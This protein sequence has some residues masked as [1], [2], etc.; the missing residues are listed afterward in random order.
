M[1]LTHCSDY[2]YETPRSKIPIPV[3]SSQTQPTSIYQTPTPLQFAST[4]LTT[5]SEPNKPVKLNNSDVQ[6]ALDLVKLILTNVQ[7]LKLNIPQKTLKYLNDSKQHKMVIESMLMAPIIAH[8]V[9][10][11]INVKKMYET[12]QNYLQLLAFFIDY[13]QQIYPQLTWPTPQQL[14]M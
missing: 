10:S 8:L 1:N 11:C 3:Q 9:K 6:F 4:P 5:K 2:G 14:M 7:Q 12:K 13:F